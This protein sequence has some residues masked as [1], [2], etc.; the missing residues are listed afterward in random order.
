MGGFLHWDAASFPTDQVL[1][2]QALCPNRA[3]LGTAIKVT[4]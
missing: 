4:A 3:S 1:V 2:F